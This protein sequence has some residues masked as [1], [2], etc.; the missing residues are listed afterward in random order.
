MFLLG[1]SICLEGLAPTACERLRSLACQLLPVPRPHT[2]APE[3]EAEGARGTGGLCVSKGKRPLRKQKR[4]EPTGA[5][6]SEATGMRTSSKV[7]A[8]VCK[9]SRITENLVSAK[10]HGTLR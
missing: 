4:S 1:R 9:R 7:S 5:R 3:A 8:D 2:G 6:K 10:F